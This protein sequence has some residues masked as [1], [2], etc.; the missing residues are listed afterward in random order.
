MS[1][2]YSCDP[3]P[4][5]LFCCYTCFDEQ[6]DIFES[7]RLRYRPLL[8]PLDDVLRSVLLPALTGR[9]PPSDLE[10]TLFTLPARLSG[11]GIGI[12]SRNAIRELHS[13]LLITSIL[14]NHILFQDHNYGYYVCQA[15]G[16]K[17][18]KPC[19]TRHRAVSQVDDPFSF[20]LSADLCSETGKSLHISSA[21]ANF[22]HCSPSG[23]KA[24]SHCTLNVT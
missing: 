8:R 3:T 20:A 7:Q 18:L 10:C 11:L 22:P 4:H 5:C 24:D 19:F 21:S 16:S 15:A 17:S 14:C 2:N 13:S 1:Y 9:P 23:L 6:V 12:P